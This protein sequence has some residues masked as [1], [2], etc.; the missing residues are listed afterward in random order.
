M[1]IVLGHNRDNL[2]DNSSSSTSIAVKP[3]KA[4]WV[5]SPK[6]HSRIRRFYPVITRERNW[7][8]IGKVVILGSSLMKLT[9]LGLNLNR[10]VETTIKIR[11][12]WKESAEVL[13]ALLNENRTRALTIIRM[14]G[15]MLW[16]RI[17]PCSITWGIRSSFN[18]RLFLK[19]KVRSR[20]SNTS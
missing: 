4:D 15:I 17:R 13:P 19:F 3:N 20:S 1:R 7:A 14:I 11:S 5:R 18:L 2:L 6:D 10:L 16:T 12:T 9:L 8:Q